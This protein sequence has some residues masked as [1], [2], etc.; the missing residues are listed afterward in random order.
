MIKVI[1]LSNLLLSKGLNIEDISMI[2]T[3]DKNGLYIASNAIKNLGAISK[4]EQQ[5]FKK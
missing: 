2:M 5:Y 4:P 1:D 3:E